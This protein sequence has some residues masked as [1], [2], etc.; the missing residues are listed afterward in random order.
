MNMHFLHKYF[1][2]YYI[3][4]MSL[5]HVYGQS[6]PTHVCFY[7]M[8]MCVSVWI[9]FYFYFFQLLIFFNRNNDYFT[10]VLSP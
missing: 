4:Y 2:I 9:S 7:A 6:F 1:V 8:G 10:G 3:I 5:N